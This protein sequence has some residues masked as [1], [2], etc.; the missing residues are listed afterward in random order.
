[1]PRPAAPRRALAAAFAV[2]A[3]LLVGCSGE[4]EF[5]IENATDEELSVRVVLHKGDARCGGAAEAVAPGGV[6]TQY[7]TH[8]PDCCLWFSSPPTYEISAYDARGVEVYRRVMTYK[9]RC[10]LVIDV[11]M[12]RAPRPASSAT[13]EQPYP[14]SAEGDV[15]I[16]N[17]WGVDVRVFFRGEDR[18]MIPASPRWIGTR[19]V[20]LW[21]RYFVWQ[22][23]RAAT[24]RVVSEVSGDLLHEQ[25]IDWDDL[26]EEFGLWRIVIAGPP[27]SQPSPLSPS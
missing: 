25:V 26:S 23:E 6:L 18:G 27:G 16:R 3:L 10:R 13:C 17:D 22:D 20:G 2:A 9:Q 4:W 14:G 8:A 21:D 7:D 24:L 1:M 5:E 19:V 12:P 15:V 11:L